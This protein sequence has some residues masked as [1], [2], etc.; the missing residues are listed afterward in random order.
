MRLEDVEVGAER[1]FCA[2]TRRQIDRLKYREV[3]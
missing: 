3:E 1:K 2:P